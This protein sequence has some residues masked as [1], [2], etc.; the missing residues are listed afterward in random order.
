MVQSAGR[1]IAWARWEQGL[2]IEQARSRSQRGD[3]SRSQAE[4]IEVWVNDAYQWRAS[5]EQVREWASELGSVERAPHADQLS[6]HE[7]IA[8]WM[9]RIARRCGE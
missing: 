4:L 1:M 8:I 7:T 6:I 3:A 2:A 9:R 5:D